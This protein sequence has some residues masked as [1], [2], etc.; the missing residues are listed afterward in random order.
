MENNKLISPEYLRLLRDMRAGQ[1][2]WGPGAGPRQITKVQKLINQ[3]QPKTVLDYG[4]GRGG[5]LDKL[6]GAEFFGYDPAV[7]KYAN[8]PDPAELVVSTDVLEHIEPELLD[9]VLSHIRA[10]TLSFAYLHIHC[11]AAHAILP[12]GRNAHLIQEPPPWWEAKILEHF[13]TAEIVVWKKDRHWVTFHAT[14]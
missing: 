13:S 7:P 3:L 2:N 12:D 1:P 11:A 8:E 9:N 6:T 10:L 14:P 4:C 5:L